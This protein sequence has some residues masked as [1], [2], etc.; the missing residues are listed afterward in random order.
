MKK[1]E[2]VAIEQ[3]GVNDKMMELVG[4]IN[5]LAA[6]RRTLT[7]GTNTRDRNSAESLLSRRITNRINTLSKMILNTYKEG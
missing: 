3:T 6:L 4:E 5:H 1:N 2:N 7:L